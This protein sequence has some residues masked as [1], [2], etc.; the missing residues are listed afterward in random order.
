MAMTG[1]EIVNAAIKDVNALLEDDL[2]IGEQDDFPL[3]GDGSVDSLT[4]IN[5]V[6]AIEDRIEADRGET[7]VI[8][9]EDL[10]DNTE[11]VFSTVGALKSFV[12]EKL[13]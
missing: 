13:G 1:S 12:V 5:L 8:I 6:S 3:F 2:Q 10:L 7:V 9:N 4:F 11:Q